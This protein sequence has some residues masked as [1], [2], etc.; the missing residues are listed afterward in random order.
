MKSWNEEFLNLLK[1][2]SIIDSI[3]QIRFIG[4]MLFLTFTSL[5]Y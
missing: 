2:V 4:I 3:R 1:T 5:I